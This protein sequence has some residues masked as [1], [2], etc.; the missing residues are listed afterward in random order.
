[1]TT[2]LKNPRVME[3]KTSDMS[4]SGQLTG[5]QSDLLEGVS[6][7]LHGMGYPAMKDDILKQ[8]KKN[9]ATPIVLNAIKKVPAR[10]YASPD[11]LLKEFGELR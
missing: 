3:T 9:G 7:S 5:D 1:M 8:A 6:T 11:E 10:H 2:A 4:G